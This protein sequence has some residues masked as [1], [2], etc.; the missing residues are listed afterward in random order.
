MTVGTGPDGG[1]KIEEIDGEPES[2]QPVRIVGA[3]LVVCEDGSI[4]LNLLD[5][6]LVREVGLQN[7]Y[8]V[9]GRRTYAIQAAAQLLARAFEAPR[10]QPF[11]MGTP[12]AS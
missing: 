1:I 6:D 2:P 8:T 5:R 12:E 9:T 3:V 10:Q 4:I 7:A 11:R